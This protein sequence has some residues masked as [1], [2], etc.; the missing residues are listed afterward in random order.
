[1]KNLTLLVLFL[2]IPTSAISE[3]ENQCAEC[4][5]RKSEMCSEECT[6][7]EDK[8]LECIEHCIKEYCAHK[9]EREKGKSE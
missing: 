1:M 3:E 5:D 8:K 7:V 9:C 6:L 2:V 4:K